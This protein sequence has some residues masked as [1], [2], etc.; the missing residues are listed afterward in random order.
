[1]EVKDNSIKMLYDSSVLANSV[2]NRFLGSGKAGLLSGRMQVIVK[3][4]R[5]VAL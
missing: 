1:L 3:S 2:D 4:F 5:I